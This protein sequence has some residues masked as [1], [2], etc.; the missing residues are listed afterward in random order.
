MSFFLFA[1]FLIVV[2][3]ITYTVCT[4]LT[5][6]LSDQNLDTLHK[7]L[8]ICSLLVGVPLIL[9]A[10]LSIHSCSAS[11]ASLYYCMLGVTLVTSMI[12]NTR[13]SLGLKLFIF[14]GGT[15]FV[16]YWLRIFFAIS[17]IG[18]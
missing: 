12:F 7:G 13:E 10:L 5:E 14:V 4:Q 18:A 8:K 2:M 17:C 16:L 3:S 15:C 1:V 9:P 11:R 6:N